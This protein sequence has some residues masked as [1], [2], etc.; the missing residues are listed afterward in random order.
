MLIFYYLF[1]CNFIVF[2]AQGI[3]G[4]ALVHAPLDM[5]QV[6]EVD[7]DQ[8]ELLRL[9]SFSISLLLIECVSLQ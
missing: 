6:L 7:I 2:Y 4:L 5:L 1:L 3:L 8:G 9:N